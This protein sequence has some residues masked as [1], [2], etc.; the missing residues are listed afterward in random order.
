[1]TATRIALEE[2]ILHWWRLATGQTLPDE[3]IGSEHC[4]LCRMFAIPNS[5]CDGCPVAISSGQS[6]CAGTPFESASLS[7]HID[8]WHSPHFRRR[9]THEL[10]FLISLRQFTP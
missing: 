8:G 1:M 5:S 3:T 9:A 10:S 7:W 2:S 4:G 6:G